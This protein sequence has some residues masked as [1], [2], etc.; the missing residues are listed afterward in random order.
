MAHRLRNLFGMKTETLNPDIFSTE[1]TRL[2]AHYREFVARICVRYVQNPH[3]AEDLTQEI[4]LKAGSAWQAFQGQCQ[5]S[6]WLYRVA[7]N[8]CLDHL[9]W[10]KRQR[11]LLDTYREDSVVEEEEEKEEG[12]PSALRKVLDRLRS[13]MD[14]MDGQVTY[15]RFELGL[16]HEVIGKICNVSRVAITK[17]L[18]KITARASELH[19]ALAREEEALA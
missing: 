4:F 5:P 17:R 7:V 6:T 16:T 15:L 8:H 11:D 19:H 13:D 9:R 18:A 3:E 14:H 1:L 10:K 12:S 2:Y